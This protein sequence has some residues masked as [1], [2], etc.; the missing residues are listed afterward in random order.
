MTSLPDGFRHR[1]LDELREAHSA[2]RDCLREMDVLTSRDRLNLADLTSAR[3]RISKASLIRRSL[4][5]TACAALGRL[6]P[7]CG[8]A[9]VESLRRLDSQM[10]VKSTSH[11]EH[12]TAKRI[13]SDWP[14]YCAASRELRADMD[15]QLTTEEALFFPLLSVQGFERGAA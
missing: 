7:D 13:A 15:K 5:T 1:L 9:V 14:G 10:R 2:V 6:G 3:F 4:F 8:K 11:V 12:W